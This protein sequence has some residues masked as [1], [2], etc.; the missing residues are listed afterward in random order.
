MAR[1]QYKPLNFVGDGTAR[2]IYRY[3]RKAPSPL[4]SLAKKARSGGGKKKKWKFDSGIL[5]DQIIN[6]AIEGGLA[7]LAVLAVT[8]G[9][10]GNIEVKAALIAFA[11]AFLIK[12]KEYR[13]IE[14]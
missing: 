3:V 14:E 1:A 13:K 9:E 6:S 7:G 8:K 4:I 12:L 10:Y 2:E 5:C 11:L